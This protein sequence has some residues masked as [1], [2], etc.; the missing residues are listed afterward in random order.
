ML[1]SSQAALRG[2]AEA[3]LPVGFRCRQA[4]KHLGIIMTFQPGDRVHYVSPNPTTPR[5]WDG[6]PGVVLKDLGVMVHPNPQLGAVPMPV[7]QQ[8]YQV[9]FDNAGLVG[10]PDPWDV[11]ETVLRPGSMV[12]SGPYQQDYLSLCNQ[13]H[14]LTAQTFQQQYC[15]QCH[16]QRCMRSRGGPAQPVSQPASQGSPAIFPAGT[17]FHTPNHQEPLELPVKSKGPACCTGCG[18]PNE[19]QAGPYLCSSCR[20]MGRS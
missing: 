4:H 14:R 2:F 6:Q 11:T 18:Y 16:N 7:A 20:Q 8:W 17:V 5:N 10:M 1:G 3:E 9:R 15:N 19:Y 13:K 12:V